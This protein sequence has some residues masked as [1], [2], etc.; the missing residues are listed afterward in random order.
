MYNKLTLV[1]PT[2][3]EK[4]SL[5]AVLDEL[6]KYDLKKLIVLE[7][8]DKETISAIKEYDCQLIYQSNK[9]YGDAIKLGI[10]NVKTEYFSI[11]NADGSFN[12]IE[13]E[14][15]LELIESNQADIVF[16][17]RYEKDCGSQDD[18][19]ITYIGNFIFTKLGNVFFKLNVTDILYTYV[20]AKTDCIKNLDLKKNDFRLCVELPIKAK[21][22]GINIKTSKSYERQRISGKKKVNAIRDGF[23]ILLEMIRLFF[24]K[25]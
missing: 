14:N 5:P 6:K 24:V 7:P 8:S 25:N 18:T 3:N 21:R 16:A 15:M 17:S 13:L 9:G 19:I 22:A 12:P 4:E 20:L 1:I 11:F 10:K 23:Y 2:K